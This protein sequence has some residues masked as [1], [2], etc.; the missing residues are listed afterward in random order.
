MAYLLIWLPLS[1]ML[2]ATTA[3]G[4]DMGSHNYAAAELRRLLRTEHAITGWVP[5]NYAGFPLFQMYFPLPFLVIAAGSLLVDPNVAFKLTTMAGALALPPAAY[6]L[7]SRRGVPHPGPALGASL[8]LLFLFQHGNSA[9]GGNL[10]S[11]LAGEFAFSASLP[12][13]LLYLAWHHREGSTGGAIA[14][15]LLIALVAVTH[16]YTVL[17][18]G[19]TSGLM[20]IL[21]TRLAARVARTAAIFVA[22]GALCAWWLLPL[23]WYS[24]W[25]TAFRHVWAIN[26][27]VEVF[28]PPLWPVLAIVVG[29]PMAQW[30]GEPEARSRYWNA[31]AVLYAGAAAA[32]LAYAGAPN[33]GIVDTRF[34]PFLQLSL[35]LLA[36]AGLGSLLNGTRVALAAVPATIVA[37]AV[38]V[39][40]DATRL[41]SWASWNYEGFERKPLW[42]AYRQISETLRGGPAQP[43]VAYEHS[44]DHEALGTIRAFESLPL[45][46][47]RSTLEGVNFQASVTSPF[48]FYVQ[49]EISLTMSCPF[50]EWGCSRPNLAAGVEHLKM[51]NASEI[52]LRSDAMK[53]SASQVPD[54][55]LAGAFGPYAV[56]RVT[57]QP[58]SYAVALAQQPYAVVTDDWKADAYRWFKRARP[59]DPVPVF[60]RNRR[61]A[62]GVPFGGVFDGLPA[63]RPA[64]QPAGPAPLVERI[65]SERVVV[66]GLTPGRAVLIR[67]SYHPRWRSMAG[68]RVWLAGP[69]FMLVFPRGDRLELVYGSAPPVRAGALISLGATVL[70]VVLAG[71]VLVRRPARDQDRLADHEKERRGRPRARA[72][73][74][75]VSCAAVVAGSGIRARHQDPDIVY[76]RGQE[77]L[78]AGDLDGA[79]ALF[80]R[81]RALAPLSNTAIHSTYFEAV[82]LYRQERWAEASRAFQDFLETY[83]EAHA[84]AESLH[85]M[86]LCAERLGQRS[87]AARHFRA[88]LEQF[89]GTIWAEFSEV[90][91]RESGDRP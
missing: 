45:F 12:L 23:L 9:W 18:I 3:T 22:A 38:L 80:Q 56:F 62:E 16:A 50:G 49:S 17:W 73:V 5:G 46:S 21:S 72:L 60:V 32:A 36:A 63:T 27:L 79:R 54:L 87:E 48:I 6:L 37:C 75:C 4:G 24:P 33:F 61:E 47:G 31:A 55:D 29:A 57:G 34:L 71:R 90:R 70:L 82:V 14:S 78:S 64:S 26:S 83:P 89:P 39:H 35:C 30:R 81:A 41:A 25:T 28:P 8:V 58:S 76:R 77:Q 51:M 2:D 15:A 68:E 52:I 53:A 13:A 65:D 7:L 67:I 84:A 88:T 10:A 42:P 20:A 11:T 43:R 1:L 85:H 40:G 19:L 74:L 44:P 69:G 86:G 66:E 91:L 59:S